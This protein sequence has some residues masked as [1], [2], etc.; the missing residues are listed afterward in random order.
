MLLTTGTCEQ[1]PELGAREGVKVWSA[2]LVNK[3]KGLGISGI[4]FDV[5]SRSTV[6]SASRGEM[7]GGGPEEEEEGM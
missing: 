3:E 7:P 4:K 2:R 5:P 6:N 1:R